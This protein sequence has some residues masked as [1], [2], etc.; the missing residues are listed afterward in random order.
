MFLGL[1][2]E[3]ETPFKQ[4]RK[5]VAQRSKEVTCQPSLRTGGLNYVV[6]TSFPDATIIFITKLQRSG[7]L[8][9]LRDTVYDQRLAVT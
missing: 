7:N 4:C 2:D 6:T 5:V 1:M 3:N 9:C 8:V